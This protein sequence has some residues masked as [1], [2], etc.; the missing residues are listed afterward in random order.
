MADDMMN[1]A[2]DRR[3]FLA[4]MVATG[5]HAATARITPEDFRRRL[6]G[7]ILSV[8]TVYNA[9]F[10]LDFDG[11]RKIVDTGANAGARRPMH[12]ACTR[13]TTQAPTSIL[14]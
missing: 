5:A 3:H 2:M 13:R 12:R 14:T 6:R 8:P 7:P 11:I 9:D 1:R 10:S 4:T